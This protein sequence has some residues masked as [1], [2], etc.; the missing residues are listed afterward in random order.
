MTLVLGRKVPPQLHGPLAGLLDPENVLVG[1]PEA[2]PEGR[3]LGVAE[4]TGDSTLGQSGVSIQVLG[5]HGVGAQV[6]EA[7][8][9]IDPVVGV[10]GE[11]LVADHPEGMVVF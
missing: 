11:V 2:P 9:V 10:G 5:D 1:R 3:H 6:E 7:Q 8:E 4:G